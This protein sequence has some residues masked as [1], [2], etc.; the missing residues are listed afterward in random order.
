MLVPDTVGTGGDSHTRFPLGISFPA[1]SGLVAF[2]AALGFMPME[3][4]A[5]ILVRFHGKRRPGISV[6][7]MVNAIPY[8]ALQKGLLTVPKEGK[9]NI[10]AG[11]VLEIEGVDD[12]SVEEAFELTDASA[13]RS[14]AGCTVNLPVETVVTSVEYN[15]ALLK[16]LVDDGYGDRQCIERRIGQLEKWLGKPDLLRRDENADYEAIIE[17]DL[18]EITEPLLAC[19]NDPDDVKKLSEVAGEKIDEAFIGSCMTHLSHLRSAAHLLDG[20]KYA[21]ARLWVAPSTRMDRD[22]VQLEGGLSVFAQVGGRVEIPGCS[23]CM[24]NQARVRPGTTVISTSTRNFDNRLGDGT[25]VYLGSTELTAIS[26]L[27]GN[28]PT[29][30]QYFQFL[31]SKSR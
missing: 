4:P 13:E 25:K 7:D 27:L 5:S 30:Q 16:T 6:R 3:M 11:T 14:A 19:P 23:L 8:V 18:A 20:E 26:A 24:G 15:V 9:K 31:E 10:F 2:A 21:E 28:L 29:V 1:G 22:T 17:I 12:L